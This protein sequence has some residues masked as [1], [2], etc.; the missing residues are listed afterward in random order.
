MNASPQSDELHL[1]LNSRYEELVREF[2]R[3]SL[4]TEACPSAVASSIAESTL[5]VWRLLCQQVRRL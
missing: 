5:C 4:L 2:A 1:A 3:E